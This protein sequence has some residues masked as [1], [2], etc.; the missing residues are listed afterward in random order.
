[1]LGVDK[2]RQAIEGGIM[3]K[4]YCLAGCVG[5]WMF[6]V[7]LTASAVM[8]G[9]GTREL[10]LEGEYQFSSQ[11]GRAVSLQ[12]GLGLFVVDGFQVGLIGGLSDDDVVT[13]LKGGGF[14]E[15]NFDIGHIFIPFTGAR[16]LYSHTDLDVTTE[17]SVLLGGYAGVKYFIAENIAVSLKYLFE[18]ADDEIFFDN[19]EVKDTNASI[20]LGMRF[21]F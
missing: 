11:M 21:Y 1:M 17:D 6:G 4:R 19:G 14:A 13:T 8:I 15:Y 7:A 3:M 9:E 5:I 2:D 10:T 16:A 20:Q 12:L 18:W